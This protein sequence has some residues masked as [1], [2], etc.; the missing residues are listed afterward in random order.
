MGR[1]SKNLPKGKEIWEENQKIYSKE[2]VN[3]Q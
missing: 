1:K 3:I 2:T